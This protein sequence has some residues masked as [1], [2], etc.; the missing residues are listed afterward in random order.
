MSYINLMACG[1]VTEASRILNS[2]KSSMFDGNL[3]EIE[4]FF[5]YQ[6]QISIEKEFSDFIF[7][8]KTSAVN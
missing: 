5:R 8:F 1:C 7:G 6:Q 2:S 3:I 4:L